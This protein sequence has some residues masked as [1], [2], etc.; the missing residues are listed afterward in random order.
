[1]PNQTNP[2]TG[3]DY[4]E[5]PFLFTYSPPNFPDISLP[6]KV[7]AIDCEMVLFFL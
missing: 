6:S 3:V 4:D 7:I 5:A 1:M 2:N